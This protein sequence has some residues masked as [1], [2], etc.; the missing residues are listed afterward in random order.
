MGG[1]TTA[2]TTTDTM[3]AIMARRLRR[4][5]ASTRANTPVSIQASTKVNI[6][7][8]TRVNIQASMTPAAVTGMIRA[9][10]SRAI[11]RMTTAMQTEAAM[12]GRGVKHV[13]SAVGFSA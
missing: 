7:A 2:A 3:A 5:P 12:E 13:C 9:R 1:P 6:P 11:H 8:N 10:A 4:T